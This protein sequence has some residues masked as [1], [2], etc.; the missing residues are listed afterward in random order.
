MLD[1]TEPIVLASRGRPLNSRHPERVRAPDES[2]RAKGAGR[3]TFSIDPTDQV[4]AS[5]RL[6]FHRSDGICRASAWFDLSHGPTDHAVRQLGLTLPSVQRTTP[7]GFLRPS[8][9][10]SVCH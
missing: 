9:P 3:L 6:T 10:G 5:L 8:R 2:A 1:W 4:R 7:W